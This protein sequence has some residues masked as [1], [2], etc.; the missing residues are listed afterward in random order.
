MAQLCLA[1]PPGGLPFRNEGIDPLGGVFGHHVT[2]YDLTGVGVGTLEP[3]LEL[4]VECSFT[5]LERTG[6]FF[7]KVTSK[8]PLLSRITLAGY[9]LISASISSDNEGS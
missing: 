2:R 8:S 7:G 6:R 4:T 9:R 1:S 3:F 5:E